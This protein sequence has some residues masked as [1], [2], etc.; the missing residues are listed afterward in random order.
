MCLFYDLVNFLVDHVRGLFAVRVVGFHIPAEEDRIVRTVRDKTDSFAH[1]PFGD[2]FAGDLRHFLQ[3]ARS[4]R[5]HVLDDDF[6]RHAA[7]QGHADNVFEFIF[8][9]MV[10]VAVG[11]RHRIPCR[12]AAGNDGNFLYGI[13]VLAKACQNRVPRLM[14]SG[15]AF[16]RL[17]DKAAL[18]LRPDEHLVDTFVQFFIADEFFIRTGG[19]N[20]SLVQKIFQICTREPARHPRKYFEVDVGSHR[21]ISGMHF[22]DRLSAAHIGQVDVDLTVETARA[23]ESGIEDIRAVGRRH[24]DNAFVGLETVH[25]HEQLVQGLFA[26]VV[27]SAEARAS[28]AADGIDLVD[29]DDT[30]LA[31]FRRV[32]QIAHTRRADKHFH[33]VGAAYREE[34]NVRFARDGFGKQRLTRSG[35]TY[36]QNT[37]R[38]PCTQ[39][40]KLFRR[41]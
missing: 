2:H 35:R 31:L 32:E 13:A 30:G 40:G 14:I 27:T 34:R 21:L 4:A 5:A 16:I 25:L 19:E 10:V 28:L 11:P 12:H 18:F 3:I 29:E 22:Q 39:I 17:C 26:F 41:F 8:A 24:D 6:F 15:D 37:L 20:S 23:K 1:T 36:E 38:D 9:H 33:E 7:A